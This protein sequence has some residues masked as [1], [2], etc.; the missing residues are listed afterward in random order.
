[1]ID[2]LDNME[3]SKIFNITDLHEYEEPLYLEINSRASCVQ[4]EGADIG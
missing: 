1:M 3:I 2:L 4:V